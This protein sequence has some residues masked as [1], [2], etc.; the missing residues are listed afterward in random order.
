MNKIIHCRVNDEYIL[1]AGVPIGAAGS[2]NDVALS[3]DFNDMWV[4]L[5]I[6]ATFISALETHTTVVPLMPSML[7]N[8]A[9]MTYLVPIPPEAKSEEGRCKLTLSGY[10]VTRIGE[11]GKLQYVKDSL[12]N[13]TTAFFRVL[14]SDARLFEGTGTPP[15]YEERILSE[16]NEFQE[17]IDEW[18]GRENG[19]IEA[20]DARRDAETER[21][22]AENGYTDDLGEYHP[23]RV[24]NEQVREAAE[25]RR[26]NAE[27]VR[28]NAEAV[29]A[30][31]ER[32]RARDE[33]IRAEN[34]VRRGA[35]FGDLEAAIDAIIEI[36]NSLMGGDGV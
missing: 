34:E 19:R 13:T 5:S 36:Q 8:G 28:A 25:T 21:E 3:L 7:E 33:E 9:T 18:E 11:D 30:N 22:R 17:T 1:D 14:P 23:G 29:R 15:S 2:S 6:V 24:A 20:E 31:A 10:S 16:L 4:G 27:A 26:A 12:T 32:I 35:V